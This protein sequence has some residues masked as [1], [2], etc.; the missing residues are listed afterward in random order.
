MPTARNTIS[1]STGTRNISANTGGPTDIL[2]I[3]SSSYTSGDKR[4]PQ[5]QPGDAHQNHVVHQQE[6]LAREQ[7]ETARRIQLR[8]PPRVQGQRAADGQHQ[9]GEDVQ[10]AG[11]IGGERMHRDQHAGAHQEGSDQAQGER[12]YGQQQ[13]PALEDAALLGDAERMD[14]RRAHQ[15]GHERGVLDRI[16]EPPA[17]PAQFVVGPPAA[18]RNADGLKQPGEDRPRPGPFGPGLIQPPL[19][20][21]RAGKCEGHR[22][23]HVAGVE[24]R[25][26][27]REREVLQ[28]RIQVRAVLRRRNQ[29]QERIRGPQREQH[30]AAADQAHDS[31]HAARKSSSAAAG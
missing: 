14:Q 6:E 26:M 15:P 10:A 5:H 8:R 20:H 25:R 29:A 22:E 16:P 7:L 2:P 28:H 11:R 18:E 13:R 4:A 27:D 17:A 12:E 19:Q 21:R 23:A 31:E 3:P 1:G 9:E 30:E 24:H